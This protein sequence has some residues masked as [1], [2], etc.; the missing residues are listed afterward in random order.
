[1]WIVIFPFHVLFMLSSTHSVSLRVYES[2][3]VTFSSS[4]QVTLNI[5]SV[6]VFI[7][8]KFMPNSRSPLSPYP[9]MEVGFI[10]ILHP[11]KTHQIFY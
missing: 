7:E 9:N 2:I 11:Q 8:S 10:L 1:M 6:L 5:F 3:F 4:S